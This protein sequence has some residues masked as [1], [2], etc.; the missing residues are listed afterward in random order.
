MRTRSAGASDSGALS[1][2][3]RPP[4]P[5]DDR[6]AHAAERRAHD[7]PGAKLL[8]PLQRVGHEAVRA[9]ERPLEARCADICLRLRLVPRDGVVEVVRL[10][11]APREQHGPTDAGVARPPQQLGHAVVAAH[12]EHAVGALERAGPVGGAGEIAGDRLDA[13]GER[14]ARRITGERTQ[15]RIPALGRACAG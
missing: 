15:T 10:D 5:P 1:R 14:H 8:G 7:V 6:D 2:S 12:Q 13:V 3:A 9:Q 4:R 11:G